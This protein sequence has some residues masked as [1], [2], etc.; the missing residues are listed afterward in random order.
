[1]SYRILI[2]HAVFSTY[3]RQRTISQEHES[4]LYSYILGVI[5]K[6]G[7]YVRAIGGMSDHIHIVFDLPPTI[8]VSSLVKEVKQ[9]SSTW[10]SDNP[11]FPNWNGWSR[12]YAIFTCSPLSIDPVI[13]YVRNQKE[14]HKKHSFE[15]EL[16]KMLES[17]NA[18]YNDKDLL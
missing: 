10:L 3:M 9:Y 6:R 12:S 8:S 13:R 17:A 14:H 4:G 18:P 2:Y 15:D 5:G 1:M 7:G 11:D 16:K